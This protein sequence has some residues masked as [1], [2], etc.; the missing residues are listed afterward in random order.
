MNGKM[1]KI[2]TPEDEFYLD[3]IGDNCEVEVINLRNRTDAHNN[4]VVVERLTPL[5]GVTGPDGKLFFVKD[6]LEKKTIII[7]SMSPDVAKTKII[8]TDYR[9]KVEHCGFPI[10]YGVC[11][12]GEEE[13]V[14]RSF[15]SNE[16]KNPNTYTMVNNWGDCNNGENICYDFY[17]REID[18]ACELGLDVVQIDDGWQTGSPAKTRI[19]YDDGEYTFYH[20]FYDGFWEVNTEKFPQGLKPLLDYAA[21]K[22]VKLGLWFAPDSRD[23]FKN[24]DRDMQFLRQAYRDGFRY[25]K[26]DMVVIK[27]Y[28]DSRKFIK[29][30]SDLSSLGD[31][32]SLQID[33]TGDIERLGFLCG[34]EHG[35]IFVENRF[36]K[37]RGYYPH[38]TLKNLWKLSRYLPAQLLQME[39]ANRKHFTEYYRESDRLA[40]V[41]YPSDY[42]F[43]SVMVSNP[44]FWMEVQ[45][46]D[47][48]D[49]NQVKSI[50]NIWKTHKNALANTDIIPIGNEP[51]GSALTGFLCVGDR[52]GYAVLLRE[53]CEDAVFNLTLPFDA[54]KVQMLASSDGVTLD[55]NEK[56]LKVKF[57]DMRQ[58]AFCRFEM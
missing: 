56:E 22:D 43:A 8:L 29:M 23:C 25:F 20:N 57:T 53:V 18:T 54:N 44:L 26:L 6:F 3:L 50:V 51:N 4:I 52:Y 55:L 58:Y 14:I 17:Y 1:I 21:K 38:T 49:K 41:T 39:I 5:H 47:E 45:E 34:F 31:D 48:E 32:I 35:K 46:L 11:S 24:Y 10:A 37:Y 42:L 27:S 19:Y 7:L 13:K 9:I 15:L 40:P 16:L 30:L 2:D 33:V 28:E 12:L 36:C